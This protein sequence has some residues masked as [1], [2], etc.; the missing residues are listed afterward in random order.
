MKNI[1]L[2]LTI[3]LVSTSLAACGTGLVG[4]PE[5]QMYQNFPYN[6]NVG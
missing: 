5:Y 1:L 6:I 4:S 2:L 3:I